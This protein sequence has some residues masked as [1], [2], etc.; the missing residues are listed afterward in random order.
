MLTKDNLFPNI[1]SVAELMAQTTSFTAFHK[2]Y[3]HYMDT[4]QARTEGACL[5]PVSNAEC[6]DLA[7]M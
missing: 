3:F 4:L 6:G 2:Q 7:N 5:K 1:L